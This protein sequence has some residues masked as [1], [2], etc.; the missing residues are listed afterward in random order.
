MAERYHLI[1]DGVSNNPKLLKS[2]ILINLALKQL[3]K[4]CNMKILKGPITVQG[5]PKNPG[6]SGVV[7]IDYSAISIHT[8]TK[9][10]KVMIDVF[11]CKPYN[12]KKAEAYVKKTFGLYKG[13]TILLTPKK[14]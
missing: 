12:Y 8:F 2:K 4:I 5:I 3:V 7:I 13:E 14:K 10:S 6:L 1:V 11:S 9:D